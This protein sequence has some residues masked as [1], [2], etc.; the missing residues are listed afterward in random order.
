MHCIYIGQECCGVSLGDLWQKIA[1]VLVVTLKLCP[2]ITFPDSSP[3]QPPTAPAVP[4]A[5]SW[6]AL[7]ELWHLAMRGEM[8][9]WH[10]HWNAFQEI[11]QRTHFHHESLCIYSHLIAVEAIAVSVPDVRQL[12]LDSESVSQL[13]TLIQP[14]MTIHTGKH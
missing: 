9:A 8:A 2:A 7:A 12:L 11:R 4:P 14:S 13:A 10:V 1:E 3:L 5:E 6:E